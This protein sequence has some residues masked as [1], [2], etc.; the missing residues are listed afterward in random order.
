MAANTRFVTG[1]HI[2][3]ILSQNDALKTSADLA[4]VLHTNPVVIR[5][6]LSSLQQADLIVSQKGPSGGSKLTRPAKSI[7]LAEVHRA[8]DSSS[9]L[10][11]P[12]SS[13][14]VASKIHAAIAKAY[15]DCHRAFETELDRV[16]LA[17]L[18]KRTQKS[19]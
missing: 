17:T 6:I 4:E 16:T 12:K 18:V 14:A 19:R 8:L 1:V 15:R 2:L 10:N 7:T 11:L 5:R 9:K 13:G 3:V